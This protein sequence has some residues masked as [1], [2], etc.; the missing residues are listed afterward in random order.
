M[1]SSIGVRYH[2]VVGLDIA[3]DNSRFVSNNHCFDDIAESVNCFNCLE[4]H[5]VQWNSG[6]NLC[7]EIWVFQG[8]VQHLGY[9]VGIER[10]KSADFLLEP[11]QPLAI[12]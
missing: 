11:A 7:D 9:P 8:I 5:L 6:A 1:T 4:M 2:H 12:L 3:M 10:S